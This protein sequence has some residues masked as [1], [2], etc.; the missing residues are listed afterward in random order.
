M[1]KRAAELNIEVIEWE[2]IGL[3]KLTAKLKK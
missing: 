3:E 1:L 2:D